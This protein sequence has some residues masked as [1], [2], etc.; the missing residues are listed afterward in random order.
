MSPMKDITAEML[1]EE[2]AF[3][4]K[5]VE[6]TESET[7]SPAPE[8]VE[9][10]P[11]PAKT[12][13]EPTGEEELMS[14]EELEAIYRQLVG[15]EGLQAPVEPTKTETVEK[16]KVQVPAP[17]ISSEE[18]H[19]SQFMP[20]GMEFDPM[21]AYTPNTPSYVAAQK[22][23]RAR[24]QQIIA[25]ERQR[26]MQEQAARVAMQNYE[27]FLASCRQRKIPDAVVA[28]FVQAITDPSQPLPYEIMLDAFLLREKRKLGKE[29][30]SSGGVP[31]PVATA[32]RVAPSPPSAN[33]LDKEVDE[34]IGQKI[35]W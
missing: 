32:S 18:I 28:R 2:D 22:T 17:E 33:A 13:E 25:Q 8:K 26:E 29:P 6:P 30:A 35:T 16:P 1:A 24:I 34:L 14:P 20:Q 7:P 9:R 21:E 23:E 3:E 12:E 19:P 10:S 5:A 31:A 4:G 11:E 15:E 27:R